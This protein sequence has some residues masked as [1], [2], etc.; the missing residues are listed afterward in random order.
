MTTSLG[1]SG[2]LSQRFPGDMS[3][4][5]LEQIKRETKVAHRS[6]HLRKTTLPRNDPIDTLDNILGHSYHHEGPFDATLASRNANK[7]YAPLEAVK[8]TNEEALKATPR[9]LV[10]DS[11]TKHVPLHGTANIP[12]GMSDM[13]GRRMSYEEGTDLQRERFAS[14]GPSRRYDD[15]VSQQDSLTLDIHGRPLPM[16][17]NVALNND[18]NI[19]TIVEEDEEPDTSNVNITAQSQANESCQD[20]HPDDLKGKGEPSYT[21]ER[22]FKHGKS[23]SVGDGPGVYEMQPRDGAKSSPHKNGDVMVRQRS[24]SSSFGEGPSGSAARATAT[25]SPF[26]G[27]S[28]SSPGKRITTGLKKRIGS[29]RRKAVRDA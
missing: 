16:S 26:G 21:L 2:S 10:Q 24:R 27:S 29:I 11:L 22:A 23:A 1:R 17:T 4:R 28:S 6:H 9:E 5:P 14:G 20:Y 13:S 15:V 8:G 12:P 25:D 18:C 3:H 7:K 19:S